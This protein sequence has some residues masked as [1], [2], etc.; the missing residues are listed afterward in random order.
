[1]VKP[2]YYLSS[3]ESQR[4]S[5]VFRCEVQDYVLVQ[6]IRHGLLVHCDPPALGQDIGH[7]LGIEELLLV[8]RFAQDDLWS[9]QQYPLFVYI[10]DPTEMHTTLA[11]PKILAWGELYRSPDDARHHRFDL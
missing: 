8:N 7:P 2:A 5:G 10:C 3:L 4:F 6:G 11:K 1:M 9:P